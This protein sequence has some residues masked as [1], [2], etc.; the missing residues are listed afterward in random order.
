MASIE[1][2]DHLVWQRTTVEGRAA[3][4]GTAGE[5]LPVLFLHGWA[6]GEYA[7][8]EI[9]EAWFQRDYLPHLQAK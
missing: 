4:Y 2:A 1:P 3:L 5:G 8:Q 9:P 6:L 7:Y